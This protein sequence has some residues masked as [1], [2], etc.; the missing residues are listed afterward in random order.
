MRTIRDV[1]DFRAFSRLVAPIVSLLLLASCVTA[2]S[3]AG[4]APPSP[5]HRCLNISNALEAPSEGAWGYAIDLK[6]I[7]RIADAGFDT[8]RLPVRWSAYT[9]ET[10]PFG[11]KTKF[12]KRVDAVI[13]HALK[14]DL[15]V[16]LNVHHYDALN[17]D[18]EAEEDRFITMWQILAHHYRDYPDGLMFEI[19]NEP[20]TSMTPKRTDELNRKI[21]REIRKSNPDRWIVLATAE[22]GAIRG[23]VQHKPKVSRRTMLTFHYYD[24]FHFTHQGSHFTKPEIPLGAVWGSEEDYADLRANFEKVDEFRRRYR[25][26]MLLGEFGVYEKAD[27]NE[28]AEWVAAVRKEAEAQGFGWCHWGFTATFNAY[29]HDEKKWVEPIREALIEPTPGAEIVTTTA[30]Q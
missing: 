18:S 16:V 2:N 20:N 26:P 12:L 21:V 7:D 4:Y 8:I 19:V 24:P 22:W 6:D 30:T 25:G 29:R 14:R 5:I 1:S 17:K 13:N 9:A 10:K 28:R 3:G 15:K 23:L 27:L 11:I